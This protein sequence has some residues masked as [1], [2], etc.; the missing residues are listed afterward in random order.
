LTPLVGRDEEV[1]LL[2]RRWARA[3]AG[4]GQVVLISGEPGIGKS[5]MVAALQE[6]LRAEPHIRLRYFCSPHYQDSSLYPSID[7]LRRAAGFEADDPPAAKLRKLEA[8]L[9]R[10][11]PANEDVA[12]LGDLLS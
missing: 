8:L 3:K 9:A 12:L 5:R 7:Q 10:A 6:C 11:A 1:E 2:M 4:A